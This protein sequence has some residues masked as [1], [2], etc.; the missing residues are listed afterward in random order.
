MQRHVLIFGGDVSCLLPV[1]L[2]ID[3]YV[4]I[5]SYVLC[6]STGYIHS[7]LKIMWVMYESAH[8]AIT[9]Q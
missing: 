1:G 9:F 7:Q 3:T 4:M 8:V 2:C 6:V 5:G